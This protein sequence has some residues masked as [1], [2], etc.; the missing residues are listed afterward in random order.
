MATAEEIARDILASAASDVGFLTVIKW[1][2]NRYQQ[3]VSRVRFRHLRKIGE[4][5]LPARHNDGTITISRGSTACAGS[6]T[7]FT[8]VGSG[9]QEYYYLRASSAWYKIASITDDD[10]LVLSSAFAEDSVSAGSYN[11]VKKLHPLDSTARWIGDFLHTRLR[12]LLEPISIEA[13]DRSA[14]GRVLVGSYPVQ[15]AQIG[16]DSNNYLMVEFYPYP[17]ES[18]IV[19]YVYWDIPS[20]LSITTTIPPQIDPYILKEGVL[21]D[22]YRYL[23][24]R[25]AKAGN[26]EA[27]AYY[28]NDYRA[29]ETRWEDRIQEAANTDQGMDDK[30]FILTALGG[31]IRTGDIRTAHDI[32]LDRWQWPNYV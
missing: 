31:R 12:T 25:A 24:S 10:N 1:L 8:N 15:V 29:Q 23:A 16:I 22:L 21:I 26:V 2:D 14:P 6:S 4:V 5:I 28:R 7:N 13:M 3:L 19:H 11:I 18:E 32:V 27:A 30:A 9:T 20:T 17:N